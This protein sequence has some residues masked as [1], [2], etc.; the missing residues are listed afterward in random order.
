MALVMRR[1]LGLIGIGLLFG[2]PLTVAAGYLIRNQLYGVRG[3]DPLALVSAV[4]I[5]ALSSALATVVPARRAASIAPM[6]A[7]RVE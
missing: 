3:T 4:T 7:L 1:A 5:L 6:N 2:L